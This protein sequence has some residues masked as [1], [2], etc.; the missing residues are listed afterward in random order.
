M[1][2]NTITPAIKQTRKNIKGFK[3]LDVA[4]D[5]LL[6]R[7]TLVGSE[8]DNDE[9]SKFLYYK[10]LSG[11]INEE[12]FSVYFNVWENEQPLIEISCSTC[13]ACGSSV[14]PCR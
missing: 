5:M 6:N 1:R 14:S 3:M 13:C 7:A 10:S 8:Y 11:W 4:Y 2:K 12:Y 9:E